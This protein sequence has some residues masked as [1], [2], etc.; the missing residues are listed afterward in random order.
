MGVRKKLLVKYS[1]LSASMSRAL[2]KMHSLSLEKVQHSQADLQSQALFVGVC[3]LHLSKTR[4]LLQH[5]KIY[6]LRLLFIQC[7]QGILGRDSLYNHHL[8]NLLFFISSQRNPNLF[9]MEFL[10]SE[11][12]K[13]TAAQALTGKRDLRFMC[14]LGTLFC[15]TIHLND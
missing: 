1:W 6:R 5:M 3:T 11:S 12:Q 9:L 2:D 4:N 10:L 14:I 8:Y 13:L 15:H 7:R